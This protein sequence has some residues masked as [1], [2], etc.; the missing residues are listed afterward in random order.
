M[1]QYRRRLGSIS[2]GCPFSILGPPP[3]VVDEGVGAGNSSGMLSRRFARRD[4]IR[5]DGARPPSARRSPD[6]PADR[7]GV[8]RGP[9]PVRPR[10]AFGGDRGRRSVAADRQADSVR[11]PE[12]VMLQT[13]CAGDRRRWRHCR[14]TAALPAAAGAPRWGQRRAIKAG[15]VWLGEPERERAQP[16]RA[17]CRRSVQPRGRGSALCV[18]LHRRLPPSTDLLEARHPLSHR[19]RPHRDRPRCN[20]DL[21]RGHLV[22]TVGVDQVGSSRVVSAS[23][24]SMWCA[25][26]VLGNR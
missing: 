15:K 25:T 10:Q 2:C 17:R 12:R 23:I 5:R 13:I 16:C 19:A 6:E 9:N 7:A 1:R 20:H 4:L 24:C 21:A 26:D 8:L 18:S 22:Q 11:R 14:R 3:G